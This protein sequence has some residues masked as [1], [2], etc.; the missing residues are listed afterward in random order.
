MKNKTKLRKPPC[1]IVEI[2]LTSHGMLSVTPSVTDCRVRHFGTGSNQFTEL[3]GKQS[4]S[5]LRTCIGKSLCLKIFSHVIVGDY[6]IITEG[7]AN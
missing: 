1:Y 5:H 6:V 3:P 4:R 2:K 7:A